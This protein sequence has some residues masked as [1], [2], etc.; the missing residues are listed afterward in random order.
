MH[1]SNCTLRFDHFVGTQLGLIGDDKLQTCAQKEQPGASDTQPRCVVSS[2]QCLRDPLGDQMRRR[3]F[4]SAAA[5]LLASSGRSRA[6][7]KPGRIG[8]LGIF[9]YSPT[10]D[11]W[12]GGLRENGWIEGTNLFVEYRFAQTLDR[13]PTL[14]SELIA[15][16]PDLVVGGGPP[17]AIALKSATATIPIVFVGVFDPVALGL[18]QSLSRPEGNVT[19]LAT[20]AP[21][22]FIAKRVEVLREIV[23]SASKIAILANPRNPMQM[24]VLREEVPRTTRDLAVALLIVEAT[25]AEEL[26]IAFTSAAAQRADAMIVLG[27]ALTSLHAP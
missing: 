11:A 24:V 16:A 15:L 12:R 17:Q 20:Y 5:A 10:L 8:Y 7:G 27:D 3:E 14:A 21:G 6:Q 9:E 19:G 2:S 26:D 23:P 4:I 22:D 1:R 13:L 18:V 25:T